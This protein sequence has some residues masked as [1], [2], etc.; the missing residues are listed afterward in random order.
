MDIISILH[1]KNEGRIA[2]NLPKGWEEQ[3]CF[4]KHNS[5]AIPSPFPPVSEY[6]HLEK[7]NYIL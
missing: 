6:E 1:Q 5:T 7:Q 3:S 2:S 4:L